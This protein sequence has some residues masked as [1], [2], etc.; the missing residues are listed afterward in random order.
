MPTVLAVDDSISMRQ[1][2]AHALGGAGYDV[3]QAVDG[4]DALEKLATRPVDVVLTD[5]HMPRMD[6]VALT[7]ALRAEPRWRHL[8]VLILTTETDVEAKQQGR[9]AGAT[10]WMSKP[11]DP[12]RL[13]RTLQQ[14]IPTHGDSHGA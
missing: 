4:V 13:L 8:P 10:G 1:I 14:V 12:D 9:E 5:H 6:G 7:R 11:F 2:L 3:C